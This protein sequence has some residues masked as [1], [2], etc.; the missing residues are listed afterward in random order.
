MLTLV[1]NEKCFVES[2]S[3]RYAARR[4]LYRAA[5]RKFQQLAPRELLFSI[6]YSSIKC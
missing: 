2:K 3:A 6:V 5:N 4:C 1:W